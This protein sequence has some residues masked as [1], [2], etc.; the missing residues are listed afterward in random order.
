[1]SEVSYQRLNCD[2]KGAWTIYI[3]QL[4]GSKKILYLKASSLTPV[5]KLCE[6]LED[7]H[8]VLTYQQRLT[9][10]DT[11]IEDWDVE[12]RPFFL[13]NYPAIHDGVTLCLVSLTEGIHVKVSTSNCNQLT[14]SPINLFYSKTSSWVFHNAYINI[15]NPKEMTLSRLLQ[16]IK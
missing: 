3:Q 7:T 1:M 15:F 2:W 11:V 10:G 5:Y 9:V 13:A 12:G 6:S 16:L 14:P 8:A 4:D